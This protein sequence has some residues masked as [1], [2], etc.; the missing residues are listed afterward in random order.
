MS[1]IRRD[2]NMSRTWNTR[3]EQN[4]HF[5]P[6]SYSPWSL[7]SSTIKL[8]TKLP[9]HCPLMLGGLGYRFDFVSSLLW[10]SSTIWATTD[11]LWFLIVLKSCLKCYIT[12][13]YTWCE[14]WNMSGKF[15]YN[16]SRSKTL[17]WVTIAYVSP[18]VQ[19]RAVWM[20]ARWRSCQRRSRTYVQF[21]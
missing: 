21:L 19:L 4:I 20:P 11:G 12:S 15:I 2:D 6:K 3:I 18:F 14:I 10:N 13:D 1:Q 5:P 7:V 17:S 9:P 8:N 16:L